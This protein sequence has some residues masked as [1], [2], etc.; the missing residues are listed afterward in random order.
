MKTDYRVLVVHPEAKLAVQWAQAFQELGFRT[1][2]NDSMVGAIGAI[3]KQHIDAIIVLSPRADITHA[4]HFL[5]DGED[6]PLC[7]VVGGETAAIGV[8]TR[9]I[10]SFSANAC[11]Q[12]MVPCMLS[13][14]NLVEVDN[15]H[16]TLPMRAPSVMQ[17]CKFTAWLTTSHTGTRASSAW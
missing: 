5:A 13:L 16:R 12:D 2:V 8:R 6:L 9:S 4:E 17:A 10:I 14:L 3:R 11:A 1:L 7:V 15:E